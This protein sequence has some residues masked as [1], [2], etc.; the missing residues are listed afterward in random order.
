MASKEEI[1]TIP[2]NVLY[3]C[4]SLSTRCHLCD[5]LNP[6]ERFYFFDALKKQRLYSLIKGLCEFH[7]TSRF[8]ISLWDQI[9]KS[10]TG[11]KERL[12][13][14]MYGLGRSRI[15]RSAFNL[16][17]GCQTQ[18]DFFN[19][20]VLPHTKPEFA[21]PLML[22]RTLTGQSNV[23][24][25]KVMLKLDEALED[26][27][28]DTALLRAMLASRILIS[29]ET[30]ERNAKS[31]L[32]VSD[33]GK[34]IFQ[35][36]L[37]CAFASSR[38]WPA[39]SILFFVIFGW[40]QRNGLIERALKTS[41]ELN[42]G[43]VSKSGYRVGD[44]R[45]DKSDTIEIEVS[46]LKSTCKHK[47]KAKVTFN[48]LSGTFPVIVPKCQLCSTSTTPTCG[49]SF[50]GG[51]E[52]N[53]I[54][55]ICKIFEAYLMFTTH[56]EAPREM[57][58]ATALYLLKAEVP[59]VMKC[60]REQTLDEL[61]ESALAET[62]QKKSG[63]IKPPLA[64]LDYRTPEG[65]HVPRKKRKQKFVTMETP[66]EIQTMKT[67]VES[68]KTCEAEHGEE[69]ATSMFHLE[70]DVA[71]EMLMQE[72][73]K[74]FDIVFDR[75]PPAM[76][77]D[78][79]SPSRAY[80]VDASPE[81]KVS[82]KRKRDDLDSDDEDEDETAQLV[83]QALLNSSE[84]KDEVIATGTVSRAEP[85][86]ALE[87][88]QSS[89]SQADDC[90]TKRPRLKSA[91]VPLSAAVSARVEKVVLQD[92]KDQNISE[93]RSMSLDDSQDLNSAPVPVATSTPLQSRQ[94]GGESE[95]ESESDG[96]SES[97][98]DSDSD[99]DSEGEGEGGE[100]D[101][102]GKQ[103]A[104]IVSPL[105]TPL[106]VTESVATEETLKSNHKVKT[107]STPVK[108]P[109]VALTPLPVETLNSLRIKPKPAPLK[110]FVPSVERLD[111]ASTKTK[112]TPVDGAGTKTSLSPVGGVP[113][114][115]IPSSSTLTAE[116]S[117]SFKVTS[118]SSPVCMSSTPLALP[119]ESS[120]SL[121]F[122][123][124]TATAD[125]VSANPESFPVECPNS[126]KS[127]IK[128]TPADGVA[129]KT[130]PVNGVSVMPMFSSSSKTLPADLPTGMPSTL[131]ALSTESSDGLRFQTSSTLPNG[132][133][134]NCN[135]VPVRGPNSF[136]SNGVPATSMPQLY[137]HLPGPSSDSLPVHPQDVPRV[138][139]PRLYPY[140][141]DSLST[142]SQVERQN[143]LRESTTLIC[144]QRDPEP[145]VQFDT[146]H[147]LLNGDVALDLLDPI[148]SE[149][150]SRSEAITA[151]RSMIVGPVSLDT[152]RRS[153]CVARIM[154][155]VGN[156]GDVVPPIELI[157]T[158]NG[159]MAF[160]AWTDEKRVYSLDTFYGAW[161]SLQSFPV[162]L[163]T[164]VMAAA[165]QSLNQTDLSR[166]MISERNRV[167][168]LP[169]TTGRVEMIMHP[170]ELLQSIPEVGRSFRA[171]VRADIAGF[172]EW[173]RSI[174]KEKRG[175]VEAIVR[176]ADLV[177]TD[178]SK[179][180]DLDYFCRFFCNFVNVLPWLE[181][182]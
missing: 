170:L 179:T 7:P 65:R 115:S 155:E 134:R 169:P 20:C 158:F 50:K 88:L 90:S 45:L 25:E 55:L 76:G 85:Q 168:W 12:S 44:V 152:G 177:G 13:K 1:S 18:W 8:S 39:S 180:I 36:V 182:K 56:T 154:R 104:R 148:A 53:R 103:S 87:Q 10:Q 163:R 125:G 172:A 99:S 178:E 97:D 138:Q 111:S 157:P 108:E 143:S 82:G 66:T 61:Y 22:T 165:L 94:S 116:C 40:I 95:E 69:K 73:A 84:T 124:S 176:E 118:S 164:I 31:L 19:S 24:W 102:S 63:E 64:A 160:R 81:V 21:S 54:M 129:T 174:T 11:D 130:T 70:C 96:E 156:L 146:V 123:T 137:A 166:F 37:P 52:L 28:S 16:Y 141:A 133:S 121:H 107:G 153:M 51:A 173:V 127:T 48:H 135:P 49:F 86:V 23:S 26:E 77:P 72:K 83:L 126:L 117:E 14:L 100:D 136:K 74:S 112:P 2:G 35:S 147:D 113:V 110:D 167:V 139:M 62:S 34:R 98:S 17:V 30:K 93:S 6:G 41:I 145:P 109:V 89:P 128:T 171:A 120:N 15:N 159:E 33:D 71:V 162:V 3:S 114:I 119:M 38:V 101:E 42:K 105:N 78:S 43:N 106:R 60:R 27:L 68:L 79:V 5:G 150:L 57:M 9:L 47:M 181:C 149:V 122:T 92:P 175:A 142:S 29:L 4:V 161:T 144:P 131:L 75:I 151:Q 46:Q 59:S 58:A 91:C 80:A 132:V 32:R 67:Y 140:L